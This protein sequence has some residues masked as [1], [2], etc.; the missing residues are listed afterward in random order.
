MSQIG[1]DKTSIQAVVLSRK[2][3]LRLLLSNAEI[4][5]KSKM[6][7]QMP[8]CKSNENFPIFLKCSIHI[9]VICLY[10]KFDFDRLREDLSGGRYA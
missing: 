5:L 6:V 2:R 7:V 1:F 10:A 9:A 4:S 3:Y 8:R